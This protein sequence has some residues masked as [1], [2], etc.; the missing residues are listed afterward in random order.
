MDYLLIMHS[1]NFKVCNIASTNINSISITNQEKS[2]LN[3]IANTTSSCSPTYKGAQTYKGGSTNNAVFNNNRPYCSS[4]TI[5]SP[6]STSATTSTQ[7]YTWYTISTEL[8]STCL[9]IVHKAI[10]PRPCTTSK[11]AFTTYTYYSPSCLSLPIL[12]II[13]D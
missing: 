1:T 3:T 2:D 8:S 7:S 5:A 11:G 6:I 13:K 9:Y 12:Y 10:P 4:G